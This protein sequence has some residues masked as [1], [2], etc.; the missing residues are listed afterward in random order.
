VEEVCNAQA[1]T[2]V[3]PKLNNN[4]RKNSDNI[5]YN[6]FTNNPRGGNPLFEIRTSLK[7]YDKNDKMFLPKNNP[8]AELENM[9]LN[10]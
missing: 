2:L 3:F 5:N 10:K 8:L 1:R 7:S 6:N 9:N 4:S